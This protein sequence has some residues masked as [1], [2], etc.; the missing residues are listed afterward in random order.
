LT[1][2]RENV[3][4]SYDTEMRQVIGADLSIMDDYERG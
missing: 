4:A 2:P 3:A 1:L